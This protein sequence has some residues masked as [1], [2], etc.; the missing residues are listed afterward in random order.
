VIIDVPQVGMLSARVKRVMADALGVS[1]EDVSD[2]IRDRLIRFLFTVT[3]PVTLG[4]LPR[5]GA[6]LPV[7]ARRLFGSDFADAPAE[8]ARKPENR[9]AP[10]S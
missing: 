3:R 6:I 2:D 10:P 8:T 4:G 7:L 1:F 9:A 5:P